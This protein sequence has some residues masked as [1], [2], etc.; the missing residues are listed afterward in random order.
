M[1]M[2]ATRR[3]GVSG[4]HASTVTFPVGLVLLL[5]GLLLVSVVSPVWAL[6]SESP[7]ST[8]DTNGSVYAIVAVG[9]T[10]YIGGEF[11]SVG[12]QSRSNVAAIDATTGRVTSWNPGA[13]RGV[14]ALAAASDGTLYLGGAFNR[15]AGQRRVKVAAVSPSGGVLPFKAKVRSGRVQALEIGGSALYVGGR[16]K[17]VNGVQ[18]RF[19]AA[20]DRQSGQLLNWDPAPDGQVWDL[21]IDGQGDLWVGG[22]YLTIGGA[23]S[24]GIAEIN[25]STGRATSFRATIRVPVYDLALTD[26]RLF[27][28]AGGRGGRVIAYSI[29]VST[30]SVLWAAQTD[31]D[32]Q[33]IDATS[34]TVYAGGHQS[35]IDGEP[36]SK[37]A[38]LDAHTGE[39][40]AWDPGASG[41]KGPYEILVTDEGLLVGGQ[42]T[43]IGGASRGGFA[44]FPGT[45]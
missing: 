7:D 22:K 44:R 6:P 23:D 15:V 26:G 45:P 35:L 39:V 1:R 11:S 37:L 16:F 33:A 19:L 36:R 5:A 32:M 12:G 43:R 38:A 18:Q 17:E 4:R 27:I 34:E 2:R 9:N 3:A 20:L 31:G 41:G 14:F 8:A 21:E 29:D 25:T 42:F 13:N 10:I 28:A 40:L 24:R 30:G